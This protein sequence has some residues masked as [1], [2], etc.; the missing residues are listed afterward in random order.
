MFSYK[1][2]ELLDNSTPLLPF[3][4]IPRIIRPLD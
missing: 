3:D 4:V 2:A 1:M